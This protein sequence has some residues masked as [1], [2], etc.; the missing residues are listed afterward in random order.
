MVQ[1]LPNPFRGTSYFNG[2]TVYELPSGED[3]F[4]LEVSA[5]FGEEGIIVYASTAPLGDIGLK[6][7]GGVYQVKTKTEDVGVKTRG[8][9]ISE[10]SGSTGSGVSEFNENSATIITK[11]E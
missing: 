2:G 6:A 8:V 4:D 1:I 10:K 9:R 7:E 3:R 11:K 5:P